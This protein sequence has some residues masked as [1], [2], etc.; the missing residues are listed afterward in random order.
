MDE[1]TEKALSEI[2]AAEEA[3]DKIS[4]MVAPGEGWDYPGQVVR[5]VEDTIDKPD[6]STIRT[7]A[8]AQQNVEDL[9]E[10]LAEE[11]SKA[12][13]LERMV[14]KLLAKLCKEDDGY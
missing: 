7:L 2:S 3:F 11:R 4:E 14:D 5:Q 8:Q 1:K 13:A 9:K 6:E 10:A 12:K